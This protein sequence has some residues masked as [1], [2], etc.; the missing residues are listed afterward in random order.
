MV[1]RIFISPWAP[2][3]WLVLLG[4]QK[5]A[6]RLKLSGVA[7]R[8]HRACAVADRSSKGKKSQ[9][10]TFAPTA[11][12]GLFILSQSLQAAHNAIPRPLLQGAVVLLLLLFWGLG[13]L[14]PL[15]TPLL[16]PSD[17]GSHFIWCSRCR[18]V[19]RLVADRRNAGNR[20]V[21]SQA[22]QA[23][24]SGCNSA[25]EWLLQAGLAQAHQHTPFRSR[26]RHP[27]RRT[28]RFAHTLVTPGKQQRKQ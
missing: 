2:K 11:K 18:R 13:L 4:E 19:A 9:S 10:R 8:S 27:C 17:C 16:L 25:V 20:P 21:G 22:L 7:A 28:H 5:S 12:Q 14:G 26:I 3:F 23:S 1:Q 6:V 15:C 24:Y